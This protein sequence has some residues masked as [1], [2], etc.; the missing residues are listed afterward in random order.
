MRPSIA[1]ANQKAAIRAATTK[2][3][4]ANPRIFGSV[5][6]TSRN[7]KILSPRRRPGPNFVCRSII[8]KTWVPA[9]AGTTRVFDSSLLKGTDADASDLDIL[10]DALPGATL[11][12]LGGLQITLE[13]LL[14]VRVDVL[15]P[16][17]L[18]KR[19]R[20]AVLCEAQS[21]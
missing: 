11:F 14:G 16:G 9:F 1:L 18:P 2:F 5:L 21:I 17:D 6:G 15:T 12:D 10:V 20:E 13:Q 8:C 7:L 4:A 3:R 19:F